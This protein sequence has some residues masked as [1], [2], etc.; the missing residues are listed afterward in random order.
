MTSTATQSAPPKEQENVSLKDVNDIS[1]RNMKQLRTLAKEL[2]LRN[3]SSLVKEE[4]IKMILNANSDYYDGSK[5]KK[6]VG[7]KAT[8]EKEQKEASESKKAVVGKTISPKD[9]KKKEGKPVEQPSTK[10]KNLK[11]YKE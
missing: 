3:Y 2:K 8:K 11:D 1:K 6:I 9:K 5:T 7:K 4:L 10:S